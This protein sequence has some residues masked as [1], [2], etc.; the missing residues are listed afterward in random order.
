MTNIYKN[1]Q[2]MGYGG[3]IHYIIP[4]FIDSVYIWLIYKCQYTHNIIVS[5]KHNMRKNFQTMTDCRYGEQ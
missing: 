2:N 1:S 3:S 4:F 5:A